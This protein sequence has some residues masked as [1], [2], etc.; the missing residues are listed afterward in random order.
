MTTRKGLGYPAFQAVLFFSG[1]AALIYQVVWQRVLTQAIGVDHIAIVFIVTI[2][3]IGLGFGSLAGGMLHRLNL[4]ILPMVYVAIELA[5]GLIGVFSLT[6]LRGVNAWFAKFGVNSISA[7]FAV[8]CVV[9]FTPIFLMGMTTPIAIQIVKERLDNFG[10]SIGKYYGCNVLGAAAGSLISVFIIEAVTLKG[11]VYVAAA[12]NFLVGAGV[13]IVFRLLKSEI[14]PVQ[15]AESKQGMP[16]RAARKFIISQ[17][18]IYAA[19]LCFGFANLAVQMISLRLFI[20]YNSPIAYLFPFALAAY[21]VLMALGQALGGYWID[22]LRGGKRHLLLALL[23]AGVAVTFVVV[24]N[25]PYKLLDEL[26][27]VFGA[28]RLEFMIMYS[29]PLA[30]FYMSPAF[31]SSAFLP[32][33]TKMATPSI[34]RA[35]ATFG[36]VL[37]WS[38]VGNILGAYLVGL[39]LFQLIGSVAC[40]L[41]IIAFMLAG[42]TLIGV[43]EQRS[44]GGSKPAQNPPI[45]S[46]RIPLLGAALGTYR[47]RAVSLSLAAALLVIISLPRDYYRQS[48]ANARDFVPIISASQPVASL[49]GLTSVTSIYV[50]PATPYRYEVRPYNSGAAAVISHEAAVYYRYYSLAGPMILD[51]K[52]RPRRILQIGMGSGEFP[53]VA[54]ELPFLERFDMVELVPE[55]V[56]AYRTYSHPAIKRTLTNP[57]VQFYVTD[58]RRF[59]QKALARGEKYDFIQIGVTGLA[60]AGISNIY[61]KDLFKGIRQLLNPGGYIAIE[62]YVAHARLSFEFFANGYMLDGNSW[63]FFHDEPLAIQQDKPVEVSEYLMRLLKAKDLSQMRRPLLPEQCKPDEV[64]FARLN[65]DAF[66][67]RFDALLGTDDYLPF[68]YSYVARYFPGWVHPGVRITNINGTVGPSIKVAVTADCR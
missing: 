1:M 18:R 52:F 7:D 55:V 61:S 63:M 57:K 62:P 22:R 20:N 35:G 8:N 45:L 31:F 30:F 4:R 17:Y 13:L 44:Y 53:F 5:I 3:M 39:I 2:F 50:N 24:T 40:V 29:L 6:V 9:L 14:E 12:L 47:G 48:F 36:T 51:P 33:V 15:P 23:A 19:A 54:K 28:G 68:E 58:G 59:V 25:M 46:T 38:T 64:V 56:D 32:V 43:F 34:Q 10:G 42:L 65:R 67:P 66:V 60:S 37:F 11:T 26:R 27:P 21:L 49:E 41:V 16:T